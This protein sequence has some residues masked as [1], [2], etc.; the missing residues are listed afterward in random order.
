MAVNP[1]LAER[2]APHEQEAVKTFLVRLWATYPDR[3]FKAVLFGSKARGDSHAESD[4]DILLVVD[5][6]DWRFRHAISDVGSDVS[7]EYGC[8]SRRPWTGYQTVTRS[9]CTNC[10]CPA[11]S[12]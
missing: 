6:D 3:I 4:I 8:V 2:L 12:R 7:L 9:R 5:S 10:R 1:Q 11:A